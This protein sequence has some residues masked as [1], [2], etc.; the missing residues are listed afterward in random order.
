MCEQQMSQ[1]FISTATL[2]SVLEQRYLGNMKVSSSES[3]VQKEEVYEEKYEVKR[4]C[5][6]AD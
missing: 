2:K 1:R 6:Q 5:R 4:E 3:R